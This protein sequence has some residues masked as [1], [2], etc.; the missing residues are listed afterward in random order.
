[1]PRVAVPH[2][3]CQQDEQ[4]QR[5]VLRSGGE[6]QH[7]RAPAHPV[8]IESRGDR[9]GRRSDVVHQSRIL[10]KAGSRPIERSRYSANGVAIAPSA[11]ARISTSSVHPNRNAGNRPKPSR[12]YTYTPPERGNSAASSA[13]VRAP[14]NASNPPSTHTPNIGSGVGTRSAMTAG[15]RKI[16]PPMVDPTSTAT[17]LQKPR[18]RGSRSPQ[19][20]VAGTRGDVDMRGRI[21]CAS[22][23][24]RQPTA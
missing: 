16:P 14:H 6:I 3:Q 20:S 4:Q 12:M 1:M 23:R 19:R 2:E 15:V 18:R 9:D 21:Y 17:A 24:W 13:Y 22:A 8:V 10:G 7:Q 5:A 11:D